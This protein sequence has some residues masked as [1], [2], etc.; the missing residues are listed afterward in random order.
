MQGGQSLAP[1]WRSWEF[2]FLSE[3]LGHSQEPWKSVLLT[4][5]IISIEALPSVQQKSRLPKSLESSPVLSTMSQL[6]K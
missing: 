2:T 5:V 6:K 1:M 3:T 4:V